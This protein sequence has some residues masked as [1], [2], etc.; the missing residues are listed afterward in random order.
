MW[1]TSFCYNNFKISFAV[2]YCT[3]ATGWKNEQLA[4]LLFVCLFFKNR[5]FVI[6]LYIFLP[7]FY[8]LVGGKVSIHIL[9]GYKQYCVVWEKSVGQPFI[10]INGGRIISNSHK[11]LWHIGK[12]NGKW[13]GRE[14]AR[15]RR[16][17]RGERRWREKEKRGGREEVWKRSEKRKGEKW[18]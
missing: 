7:Y 16:K 4:D 5:L 6:I 9:C 1:F 12:N 10:Q 11:K 3:R 2:L 13:G 18:R 15:E 8:Y 17:R 14:I